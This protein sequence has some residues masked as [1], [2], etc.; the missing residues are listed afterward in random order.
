MLGDIR[1][2]AGH[3]KRKPKKYNMRFSGNTANNTQFNLVCVQ[4]KAGKKYMV[5]F[6]NVAFSNVSH[7]NTGFW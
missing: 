3:L 2:I 6:L 5:K 7:G 4:F 1:A